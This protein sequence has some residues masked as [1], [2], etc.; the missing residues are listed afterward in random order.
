MIKKNDIFLIL[1]LLLASAAW[2]A[3]TWW[4]AQGAAASQVEIWQ[5]KVLI[6]AYPLD[7]AERIILPL[8][9]SFGH[10]VVV[11]ENGAV[12]IME[13]DCPDQVC[14][15]T[16]AISKPGQTIVCLPNRVVVEITG[17]KENEID[18]LSQ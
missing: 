3:F 13:S 7:S 6:D 2:W 10:N 15:R 9:S 8:D 4:S 14:V 11:I 12:S 17:N 5:D 1:T 18:G 16:G